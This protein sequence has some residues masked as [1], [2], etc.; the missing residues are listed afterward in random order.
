MSSANS[1][2]SSNQRQA[3]YNALTDHLKE[4]IIKLYHEENKSIAQISRTLS[5]PWSTVKK[6]VDRY[7]ERGT[8]D[9]FP[10]GGRILSRVKLLD[11]HSLHIS[12][13]MDNDCQL[14]LGRIRD[15]LF[16]DFPDLADKGISVQQIHRHIGEKIGFTLKQIKTVVERRNAPDVILSRKNFV[17]NLH[18]EGISYKT[19]CIFVD[20][21][22]FNANL[23]RSRGWS[24]KGEDAV[25]RELPTSPFW[26]ASRI[27]DWRMSL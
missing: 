26:P 9:N 10:R 15:N 22:G 16:E 5:L 12:N 11:E 3:K 17:L 7:M 21:S 2:T 1:S 14:T 6:F 27:T 8:A 18:Q 20:E 4:L 23:I 19:N 25:S 13:Q 24:K